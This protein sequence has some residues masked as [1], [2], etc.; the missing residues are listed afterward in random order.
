MEELYKASRELC[1]GRLG[2]YLEGGYDLDALSEVIAGVVGKIRS[3]KIEMEHTDVKDEDLI[4]GYIVD[5]V[6][7]IQGKYWSI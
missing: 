2:V 7:E 4:A 5:E 1:D 6:N 3:K